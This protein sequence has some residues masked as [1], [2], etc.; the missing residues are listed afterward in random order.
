MVARMASGRSLIRSGPPAKNSGGSSWPPMPPPP[1]AAT[2][3]FLDLGLRAV[4]I[5]RRRMGE[6]FGMLASGEWR[7]EPRLL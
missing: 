7:E 3:G 5:E 2:R 1:S 6:K 4:A